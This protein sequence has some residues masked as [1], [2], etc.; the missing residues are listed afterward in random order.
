[1]KKSYIIFAAVA[2]ALCSCGGNLNSRSQSKQDNALQQTKKVIDTQLIVEDENIEGQKDKENI[3]EEVFKMLFPNVN[4]SESF[5]PFSYSGHYEEECEGCDAGASVY[6]YP[7]TDDRYLVVTKEYFAGPGCSESYYY[8]TRIYK[9]G[10]LDTVTGVLPMPPLDWLLN[11]SKISNYQSQIAEFRNMYDNAPLNYLQYKFFP[12]DALNVGLYPFDCEDVLFEMD[13]CMLS[14]YHHDILPEYVWDGK[15]FEYADANNAMLF[16]QETTAQDVFPKG[17]D[18][19]CFQQGDLNKDG[20]QDLAIVAIPRDPENMMTRDDGYE[21]NFN[22]PVLAIYFSKDAGNYT[23]FKEY[24]N[25]LPGQ[26]DEFTFVSIESEITEKGVLKF[27]VSS[28]NS[29]GGSESD[30]QSYLFRFQ[31][32]DFYLIGFDRQSYSRLTGEAEKVSRNYL[33]HKQLTTTYNMFD[34]KVIPTETWTDLPDEPLERLGTRML[35]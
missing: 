19:I 13:Q 30:Q 34:D 22:K 14:G 27:D 5:S 21:Y 18:T 35:D 33:T 17:C 7:M 32:D 26:E 3:A 9:N 25:T 1:M 2:F 31:D 24:P 12:P 4:E 23:L 10:A 29:A 6:C 16:K 28:F 11:P 8:G 20:I 15:C